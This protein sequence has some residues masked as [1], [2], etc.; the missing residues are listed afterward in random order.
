MAFKQRSSPLDLMAGNS[1][2]LN[3]HVDK[4]GIHLA[5]TQNN[6][7]N[8]RSNNTTFFGK[9]AESAKQAAKD[10]S[11]GL[12][13]AYNMIRNNVPPQTGLAP[14]I[15]TIAEPSIRAGFIESKKAEKTQDTTKAPENKMKATPTYSKVKKN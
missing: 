11:L 1:T 3:Q 8:L 7:Q 15:Q 2:P 12:Y 13:G 10:L 4:D 14:S 5:S 6:F 9:V